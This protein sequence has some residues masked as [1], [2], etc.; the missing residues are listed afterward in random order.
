MRLN[1]VCQLRHMQKYFSSTFTSFTQAFAFR[2]LGGED[3][4]FY[5]F[6][7]VHHVHLVHPDQAAALDERLVTSDSRLV[8]LSKIS[9]HCRL[10]GWPPHQPKSR[11]GGDPGWTGEIL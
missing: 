10:G 4:G 5:M 8:L 7:D 6:T 11:V 2:D 1:L 3:R 9:F